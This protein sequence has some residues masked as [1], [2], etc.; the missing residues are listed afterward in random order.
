MLSKPNQP[1]DPVTH[2]GGVVFR[3]QEGQPYYLIVQARHN[4][5]HWILPKGHVEPGETPLQ[6]AVREV[7]EETG[8]RAEVVAELGS[9]SFTVGEQEIKAVFYLLAY[10][11]L[12]QAQE[13]RPLG[14]LPFAAAQA[15]LTFANTRE[16]LARAQ[17]R[18][19]ELCRQPGLLPETGTPA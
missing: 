13:S 4:P 11:G 1:E 8:V 18:L 14:W 6:T 3:L 16:L 9:I 19:Q 7:E 15:R 17:A 5:R 12:G 2:A 10:R